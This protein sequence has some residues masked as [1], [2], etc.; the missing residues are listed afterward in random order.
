[1]GYAPLAVSFAV[2]LAVAGPAIR[3][4][5]AGGWVRE[6]YRG[7][8]P[9]FPS[10]VVLVGAALV[11]LVP[12]AL[13]GELTGWELFPV[14]SESGERLAPLAVAY[15]A[16]VAL[17]GLIDDLIGRSGEPGSPRGWRGH[18]RALGRGEP[19]TGALKAAGTLG[20]AALVLSGTGA[21]AGEYLIA[22]GIFVGA[23]H[24]FNLLDTRPGRA[25]KAFVL[26]AAPLSLA[27]LESEPLE[28]LGPFLGPLA[29]VG[30]YNLRE[31]AMLGDT[32]AGAIGALAGIWLV[33]C[34]STVSIA[35]EA[36]ALALLAAL[37]IYGDRRSLGA[38]VERLPL[39]K[40]LD[41]WGRK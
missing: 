37:A 39:V 40:H 41:S 12:L 15:V 23:T 31:R 26:L 16:G 17:L 9:A 11:A 35:A 2:A 6:N 25:E 7:L 20:L 13:A 33:M 21:G 14:R 10:G 1:M 36:A 28:V 8:W 27:T 29:V 19:A 22:V 24:L 34:L 38:I 32:G 4:L 5:A 3:A 18:L 30:L